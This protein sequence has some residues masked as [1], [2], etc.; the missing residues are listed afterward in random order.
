MM[1]VLINAGSIKSQK[2]A[3]VMPVSDKDGGELEE[4]TET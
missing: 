2:S 3:I 4:Q 1:S